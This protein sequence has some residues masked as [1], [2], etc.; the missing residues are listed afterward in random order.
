MVDWNAKSIA[1]LLT[2]SFLPVWFI[3][4]LYPVSKKSRV[5][6]GWDQV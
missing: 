4:G 3:V 2:L 6:K 5:I 1:S